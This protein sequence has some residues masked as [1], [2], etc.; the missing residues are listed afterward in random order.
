M[1]TLT[2][3]ASTV[4]KNIAAQSLG[5]EDGGLRVSSDE[6][7]GSALN[8]AI[9]AGPEPADEV[10]ESGGAHVYL[11]PIVATALADK[12]LDAEVAEDGSVRFAIGDQE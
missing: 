4:V 10:I 7:G 3:T 11:E 9:A 2:E 5:T 12:V 8:V 1:L 6:A